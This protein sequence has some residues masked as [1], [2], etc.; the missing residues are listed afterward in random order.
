MG[1]A[2]TPGERPRT[3][4]E[5]VANSISHGIGLLAALVAVPS[6]LASAS[7]RDGAIPLVSAAV[8][9]AT[10]ILLYLA[11]TLYHALPDGRAKRL[12][13]VLDNAAIFLLIAGTY[14]P[15]TLDILRGGWGWALFGIVWAL[16]VAGVVLTA[17]GGVRHRALSACVYLGM[18]WLVLVAIRPLSL[19]MPASGVRL[20]VA[21]GLAYT[22]GLGF[23]AARRLRYG[24]LVWHLLALTGTAC[25]FLAILR[26][27]A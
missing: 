18:G 24:H 17:V 10:V 8:F 4:G 2:H 12:F 25:H 9:G 27:S 21:G 6:L 5:E 7:R 15:F 14:T 26:H 22:A 19:R 3:L 16:A 11:S 1:T 20:L 23:Y 13:E